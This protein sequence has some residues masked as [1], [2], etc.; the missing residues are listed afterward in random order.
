MT[1]G[2]VLWWT[3]G[4]AGFL[5]AILTNGCEPCSCPSTP[6]VDLPVGESRIVTSW[7]AG[8]QSYV[9][10]HFVS[11][12]FPEECYGQASS[13]GGAGGAGQEVHYV[14]ADASVEATL[15]K[16]SI[17]ISTNTVRVHFETTDGEGEAVYAIEE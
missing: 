5:T 7:L 16:A 2:Y 17:E 11:W 10:S 9:Q 6:F 14:P 3:S 12:P 4:L 13:V 15:L 1:R 8:S